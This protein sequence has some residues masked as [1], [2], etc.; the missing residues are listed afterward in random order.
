MSTSARPTKVELVHSQNPAMVDYARRTARDPCIS[1]IGRDDELGQGRGRS[2]GPGPR[3]AGSKQGSPRP[4]RRSQT[5]TVEG[6]AQ[7]RARIRRQ[8]GVSAPAATPRSKLMGA[9]NAAIEVG[10]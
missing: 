1:E 2:R 7:S 5:R 3:E 9:I 8:G 10:K 6:A 4:P